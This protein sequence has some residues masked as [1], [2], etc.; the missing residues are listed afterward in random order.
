MNGDKYARESIIALVKSDPVTVLSLTMPQIIFLLYPYINDYQI[1]PK[2]RTYLRN[3]LALLCGF[4][5]QEA[6]P[7]RP[8]KEWIPGIIF[9]YYRQEDSV[10]PLGHDGICD[11]MAEAP[12]T[13][14]ACQKIPPSGASL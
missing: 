1:D 11:T 8:T 7:W 14:T 9:T 10:M 12:A 6:L 13:D 5:T 3:D 2:I 4:K